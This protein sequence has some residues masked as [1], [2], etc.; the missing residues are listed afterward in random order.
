MILF[1]HILLWFA[2]GQTPVP[3]L[4][5]VGVATNCDN[6]T[7]QCTYTDANVSPGPHFYFAVAEDTNGNISTPSNRADVNVPAGT[8]SVVLTWN[9]S[10]TP[11]VTYFIFRGSVPTNLTG[12]SN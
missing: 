5:V 10:T 4:N 8:H 9:P 12:T 6:Q 3:P 11:N 7:I 1:A 2:L